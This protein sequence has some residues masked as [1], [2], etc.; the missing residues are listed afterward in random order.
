MTI[1][2]P[3]NRHNSY[4]A[5][6]EKNSSHWYHQDG[7]PCFTVPYSD[8]KRAEAG[9]RRPTTLRD[10]R[11]MKLLPSV[12]TIL[13]VLDKPMVRQW[14]AEQLILAIT[15]ATLKPGETVDEMVK[16]VIVTEK[17]HDEARDIAAKRGTETHA[18]IEA[19]LRGAEV[20]YPEHIEQAEKAATLVT[21]EL[22][23]ADYL[24]KVLVGPGYAGTADWVQT[25]VG[26]VKVVDFK[27][28]RSVPAKPYTEH[29]LQAAA[30]ARAAIYAG[31]TEEN[32]ESTIEC[33]NLYIPEEGEPRLV[34]HE[35]NWSETYYDGFVSLLN[36]WCWKSDYFTYQPEEI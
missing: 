4:S 8:K 16:R 3:K 36:F 22:G 13:Q 15:T 35:G 31:F 30:Y 7:R 34:L 6:T 29:R 2:A 19:I 5:P 18:N 1:L 24:E 28:C 14:Q 26:G 11:S 17:S 32:D 20:P 25:T 21:E 27:T 12:T 10:A 9:E 33:Y 23:Q